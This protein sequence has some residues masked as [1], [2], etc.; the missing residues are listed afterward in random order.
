MG[1]RGRYSGRGRLTAVDIQLTIKKKCVEKESEKKY[2]ALIKDYFK[3][4]GSEREKALME[5]R[6]SALRFFLETVDFPSLRAARP[7][8]DASGEGDGAAGVP[9]TLTISE[10]LN[11]IK[12]R[13]NGQTILPPRR[14]DSKK[15]A[16]NK[17]AKNPS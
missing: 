7:E 12:L 5:K 1:S 14:I 15:Q 6:L 17:T 10:S 8:L 3:K 9:V 2:E 11:E 16:R 13:L 4:N